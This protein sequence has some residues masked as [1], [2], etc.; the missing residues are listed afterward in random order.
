MS[1]SVVGNSKSN[2]L[3][4]SSPISTF[5]AIKFFEAVSFEKTAE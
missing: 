2:P 5:S 4:L 1:P 3:L